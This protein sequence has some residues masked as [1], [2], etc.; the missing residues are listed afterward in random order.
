MIR[1]LSAHSLRVYPSNTNS[2]KSTLKTYV[3]IKKWSNR[4]SDVINYSNP[5]I[6]TLK[7]LL[8]GQIISEYLTNVYDIQNNVDDVLKV[9]VLLEIL[10][11]I[12]KTSIE[13]VPPFVYDQYAILLLINFHQFINL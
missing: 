2:V 8:K 10:R 1:A 5:L 6:F 3:H 11:Y 9:I 12:V 13:K 4:I 7:E